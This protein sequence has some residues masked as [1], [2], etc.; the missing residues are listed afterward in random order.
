MNPRKKKKKQEPLLY[1]YRRN[2]SLDSLDDCTSFTLQHHA[3]CHQCY[4]AIYQCKNE[5]EEAEDSRKLSPSKPPDSC[6]V[7]KKSKLISFPSSKK[8][9]HRRKA[10]SVKATQTAEEKIEGNDVPAV[11]P[12]GATFDLLTTSSSLNERFACRIFD[13]RRYWSMVT[14]QRLPFR[15]KRSNGSP[16]STDLHIVPQKESHQKCMCYTDQHSAP[17]P[18]DNAADLHQTLLTKLESMER[19]LDLLVL[20]KSKTDEEESNSHRSSTNILTE[21]LQAQKDREAIMQQRLDKMIKEKDRLSHQLDDLIEAIL[22]TQ[23]AANNMTESES[24]DQSASD[25]ETNPV[26]CFSDVQ[27]ED[28][29]VFLRQETKLRVSAE[30]QLLR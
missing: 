25:S 29:A 24:T 16:I 19:R 8:K 7:T 1:L 28:L 15:N 30:H 10:I 5:D 3:V 18:N 17:L 2:C 27:P 26:K 9:S 13:Q 12:S 20:Q 14:R 22:L 6:G 11:T 4:T 23:F 21:I